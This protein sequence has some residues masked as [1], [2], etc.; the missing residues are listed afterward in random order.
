MDNYS[1]V[2]GEKGFR[3]KR[4]DSNYEVARFESAGM[5]YTDVGISN[6]SNTATIRM[7]GGDLRVNTWLVG[8]TPTFELSGDNKLQVEGP[9]LMNNSLTVSGSILPSAD[10]SSDLGSSSKRFANIFS[11]DLQLSNENTQGNEVDGTTGN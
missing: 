2:V 9:T 7:R 11:A 1:E 10:A 6:G 3:F 8:T 4:T 5:T